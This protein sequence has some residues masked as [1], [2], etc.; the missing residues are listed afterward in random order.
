M[1]N[2]LKQFVFWAFLLILFPAPAIVFG[3]PSCGDKIPALGIFEQIAQY[4][5]WVAL[6][7]GITGILLDHKIWKRV[8]LFLA[9]LPL[10]GWGYVNFMII[11]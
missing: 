11:S 1:S 8:L 9:V 2:K 10:V 6:L 4:S 7:L 3:Q 5:I